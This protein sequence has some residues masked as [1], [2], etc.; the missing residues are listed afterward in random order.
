[1]GVQIQSLNLNLME[2]FE[3]SQP[4]GAYVTSVSED[5]PADEAGLVPAEES[6]GTGGD[7]IVAIDG[8]PVRDTEELIAYLVFQS[9]V[10]QTVDLTVIRDGETINVPL[11]LGE[12][13]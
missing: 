4:S 12:R 13:P 6:D 2:R 9:D 7:L 3:L 10:G 11:T 8:T 1:M 5:G